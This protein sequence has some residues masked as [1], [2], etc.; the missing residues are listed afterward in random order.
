M[1]MRT[2][3]ENT[4]LGV[5]ISPGADALIAL[6]GELDLAGVPL[7]EHAV[8]NV[9]HPQVRRAVLDLE[10][11]AFIDGAGL[12]AVLDLLATCLEAGT[13][14]TIRPGPRSVQRVFELTGADRLLPF[15]RA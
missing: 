1:G 14:L 11:L 4:C 12:H 5:R 9:V 15:S 2:S 13:E 6:S 7:F 10:G 8:R 3:S